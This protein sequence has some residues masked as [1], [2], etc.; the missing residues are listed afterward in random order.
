MLQF[1]RKREFVFLR[2]INA[3]KDRDKISACGMNIDVGPVDEVGVQY[4]FCAIIVVTC[5]IGYTVR[6][7]VLDVLVF[8]L[9]VYGDHLT[10]E[11]YII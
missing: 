9:I 6:H 4:S 1:W 7:H 5:Q 3:Q 10:A 11:K 8:F 2:S